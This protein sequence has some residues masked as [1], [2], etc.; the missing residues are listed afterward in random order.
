MIPRVLRFPTSS[1]DRFRTALLRQ[2]AV[3]LGRPGYE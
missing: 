3:S 1:A 2:L